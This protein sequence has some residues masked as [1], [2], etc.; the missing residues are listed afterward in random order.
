M[1]YKSWFIKSFKS[2][3]ESLLDSSFLQFCV[4]KN[5]LLH[6][7]DLTRPLE[8]ETLLDWCWKAS[9]GQD[10]KNW[11]DLARAGSNENNCQCDQPW[12]FLIIHSEM[13]T[14]WSQRV[15]NIKFWFWILSL[16][17]NFEKLSKNAP[18]VTMGFFLSDPA[19]FRPHQFLLNFFPRE[20]RSIN[21]REAYLEWNT[22]FPRLF[23]A[24]TYNIYCKCSKTDELFTHLSS[25]FMFICS[26]FEN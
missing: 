17:R 11:W 8:K 15:Q 13:A 24:A 3:L 25:L 18:T 4:N 7:V 23:L 2:L 20:F 14:K 10:S 12:P 6:G 9:C 1:D 19:L 5:I 26:K 21:F 16:F 22:F